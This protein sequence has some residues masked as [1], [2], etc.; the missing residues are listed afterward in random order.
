MKST[1]LIRYAKQA[2]RELTLPPGITLKLYPHE[3]APESTYVIFDICHAGMF[4]A[5]SPHEPYNVEWSGEELSVG[6]WWHDDGL[7]GQALIQ[8]CKRQIFM[9]LVNEAVHEVCEWTKDTD[10]KP[11]YCPHEDTTDQTF[12]LRLD[13]PVKN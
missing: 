10:G 4:D 6:T 9:G 11:L 2:A 13:L 1:T 8:R 7:H 12:G 5:Y 3:G